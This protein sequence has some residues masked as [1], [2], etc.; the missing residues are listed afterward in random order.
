MF[1]DFDG[2]NQSGED[3][4]RMGVSLGLSLLIFGALAALTATVVATAKAVV[5][6]EREVTVE[7]AQLPPPP[8]RTPLRSH[9]PPWK[10]PRPTR[11]P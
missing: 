4:G 1:N 8:P 7:F 5:E 6:R 3:R 2:K 9:R 11:P 10:P